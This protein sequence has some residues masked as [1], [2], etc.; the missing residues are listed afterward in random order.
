MKDVRI[1]LVVL[2]AGILTAG[3]AGAQP[4][5]GYTPP[6]PEVTL[7][8]VETKTVPV[9]YE[10]VGMTE[11]SKTVEVRARVQGFLET[12]DFQEGAFVDAGTQL[13]TI[14]PRSFKA[15]KEI[16]AAQVEDAEARLRLADQEVKRL[17]SVRQPGA[18][19]ESD[20][21]QKAASL[22]SATAAVRLAKAQ[23]AKADLDLSY[24]TVK[25]PLTGFVGKAHKE[26][27]SLVDSNANSLLTDMQQVDPLYVSFKVSESDY[28]MW[29]K[30]Q[31][32]GHL[33]LQA[34]E[35]SPRIE[36][37]LQDGTMFEKPGALDFENA[38]LNTQTGTVEM[39]ATFVNTDRSL[40]PGQFVKVFMKGWER[41][42]SLTVPMR[43]V[44]Q[45]PQGAYVY[46]VGADNKVE[47]RAVKTGPWADKDWIILDGLKTGEHVIL[48][49][50]TKVQP[51]IVVTPV[52][53][54]DPAKAVEAPAAPATPPAAR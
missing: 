2:I 50:L 14:D 20:I 5:K 29:K 7:G 23:L 18:V 40:K 54:A 46:V 3:L 49:G 31:K 35:T 36:I 4:P 47:R 21:D 42:N 33:T 38:S 53:P 51:G 41:P 24:T 13:F 27:G 6:P 22:S 8:T 52:A 15:D 25:A 39:R 26:I 43:A 1:A 28:L 17:K 9:A 11:A 16:A 34:G 10:Y 19:A 48:E 37:A 30:E 32:S 44:G 12:R 45:S